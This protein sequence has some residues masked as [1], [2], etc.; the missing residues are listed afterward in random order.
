MA[1]KEATLIVRLKDLA[2]KEIKGLQGAISALRSQFLLIAGVITGTIAVIWQMVKAYSENEQ[3]VNRLNVALRNQGVTN[4]QVS[5]DLQKYAAELAKVTTFTDEA[6][7]AS[8]ALFVTMGF[9]SEKVKKATQMAAD[10]AA[11]M[12]WDL[13]QATLMVGKALN[14]NAEILK[15]YGLTLGDVERMHG[16]AAAQLGTVAGKVQNLANRWGEIQETLGKY[17]IPTVEYWIRVMEKAMQTMEKWTGTEDENLKGRQLTIAALQKEKTTLENNLAMYERHAAPGS[18]GQKFYEERLAKINA[19]IE[20]EKS[21]LALET[22]PAGGKGGA[23]FSGRATAGE[24]EAEQKERE[25]ISKATQ[26]MIE[27]MA[28]KE[29]ARRALSTYYDDMETARLQMFLS[30]KEALELASLLRSNQQVGDSAKFKEL[31][32]KALSDA[33]VK[34]ETEKAKKVA[35]LEEQRKKNFGDTL[36][37]I[38]TLSESKNKELAVIGKAASIAMA[39]IYTYEAAN[40][41]LASAPP[42][43][44]FALAALC[45][46]AGLANVAKIAGVQM[47]QGGIIPAS[48]GGTLATIGEG[49]RSEAV[50]PLGDSRA[51]EALGIGG[52]SVGNVYVTVNGINDPDAIAAQVGQ[53]IIQAIR[54]QGQLNFTR[55]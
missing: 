49:G 44:N 5:Q 28:S 43:W 38:S 19:A 37:F 7:M 16:A 42:P 20:R 12:G 22:S 50:I 24:A 15:R 8:E 3:A 39:Y 41:A 47:A 53:K 23:S 11:T 33:E 31:K 52:P 45:V 26:A 13:H 34:Y 35:I 46:A 9:G 48:P 4:Q 6:L 14:G 55:T 1:E 10:L 2:S 21:L 54:G 27:G 25:K 32:A 40:K 51:K 36:Q 18:A 30:N 29:D 17:L